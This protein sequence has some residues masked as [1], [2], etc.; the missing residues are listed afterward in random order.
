LLH[1]PDEEQN[2][3]K[4][5]N[6]HLYGKINHVAW[7]HNNHVLASAGDDG[8][9]VLLK[10]DNGAEITRYE[11]TKGFGLNSLCFSNT[12]HYL[13]AG[14][15]DNTVRV[16]DLKHKKMFK[17]FTDHSSEVMSVSCNIKEDNLRICSSASDGNIYINS[18]DDS[19]ALANLQLNDSSCR[20]AF[21]SPMKSYEIG[22]G[23]DDGLVAVWDCNKARKNFVFDSSHT[24][25][26]TDI[27]FSPVNH[28]LMGSVGLDKQIIFYDIY[29]NKRIVQSIVT[30]EALSCVTFC[31]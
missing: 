27:T 19:K 29:K 3:L 14:S 25:A 11:I 2:K 18:L 12:S 30:K 31:R 13:M 20:C 8:R 4:I 9:V 26:C 24:D 15:S 28:M 7:S 1:E 6:P 16:F 23:H 5:K 17:T 21:F 22:S 10:S